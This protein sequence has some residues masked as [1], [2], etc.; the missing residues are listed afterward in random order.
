MNQY[1]VRFS[2]ELVG[3]YTIITADNEQQ[4][5]RLAHAKIEQELGIRFAYL[6]V[7]VELEGSFELAEV[8]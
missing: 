5:I 8:A 6:E 4:A 3:L 2:L 7:E 1:F